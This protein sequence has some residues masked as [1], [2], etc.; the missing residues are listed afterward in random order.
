MTTLPSFFAGGVTERSGSFVSA[1]NV[2]ADALLL[3]LVGIVE[4]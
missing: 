4:L 1:Q 2:N 3:L